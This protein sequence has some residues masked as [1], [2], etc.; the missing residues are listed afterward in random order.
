MGPQN[1]DSPAELGRANGKT[2]SNNTFCSNVVVRSMYLMRITMI[3][4]ARS[5]C[6]EN[7]SRARGKGK[8]KDIEALGLFSLL[9][10]PFLYVLPLSGL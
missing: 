8:W 4:K 3:G 5:D 1:N 2:H 9:F 10:H 7:K 6:R